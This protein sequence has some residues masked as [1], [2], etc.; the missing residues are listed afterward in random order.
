MKKATV[1][2]VGLVVLSCSLSGLAAGRNPD[3]VPAYRDTAESVLFNAVERERLKEYLQ[4]EGSE[5]YWSRLGDSR[6]LPPGLQ[7]K[8]ARGGSLPPGWRKKVA[9]GEVLDRD[10]A[11]Y[12]VTLPE[13]IL[14]RLPR[15]VPGTSLRQIDDRIVRVDDTTRAILDVLYL[16]GAR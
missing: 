2:L 11:P 10:L 13:D 16:T 6:S 1:A 14:S 5:A 8:V 9:R 3:S 7:K 4:G 15:H 12:A